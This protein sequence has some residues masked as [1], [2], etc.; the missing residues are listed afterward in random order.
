MNHD[1]RKLELAEVQDPAEAIPVGLDHRAFA[2][3]EIDGAAQLL[4]R[5]QHRH[6]P[7]KIDAEQPKDTADDGIDEARKRTDNRDKCPNPR[8]N[9]ERETVR[10]RKRPAL[11]QHCGK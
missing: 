10:R 2:M 9:V 3:K 7:R 4:M 11:W 5:R 1:V 6:F 8:S